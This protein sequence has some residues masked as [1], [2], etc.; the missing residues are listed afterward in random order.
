MKNKGFG[1][2]LTLV[3]AILAVAAMIVYPNVMYTDSTTFIPLAIAVALVVIVLVLSIVKGN[4]SFMGV[5][6]VCT[7]VC[8]AVGAVLPVGK[9]VNE[10]GYVISGLDPFS[11]I[12]AFVVFE[13]IVVVGMLLSIIASFM[14]Q[15]K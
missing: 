15:A 1:F 6:P 10:I 11:A 12:S 9:M 13:V 5:L 7:T 14:K 4:M 2:Y 8:M 3:T